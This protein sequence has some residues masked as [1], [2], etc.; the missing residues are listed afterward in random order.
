MFSK[1]FTSLVFIYK[2]MSLKRFR[3]EQSCPSIDDII[4]P[5][6]EEVEVYCFGLAGQSIDHIF[7]RSITQKVFQVSS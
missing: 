6:F 3:I 4:M 1:F 7:V 2:S 5:P